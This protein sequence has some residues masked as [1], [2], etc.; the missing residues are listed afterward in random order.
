MGRSPTQISFRVDMGNCCEKQLSKR[1]KDSLSKLNGSDK[2]SSSERFKSTAKG[3][4]SNLKSKQSAENGSSL[5]QEGYDG[6]K[7]ASNSQYP[8]NIHDPKQSNIKAEFVEQNIE[9]LFMKYKA[10][11]VDCILA[12]G[13]E[14]LC[15]DLD[16]DPTEFRVLLLAWKFN[17]SQMCRFTRKEF[18]EGCK[19]LRVDS[20]ASLKS[21]L[22][23][24]EQ[25][26]EDKDIFRDLYRFTYGFGLDVEDGQRTLP[27]P[28]A[29]DLWK[30]VFTKNKPIFLDGWF[31][32]LNENQ[33]KGISRDTWNMFL[34][35]SETIKPDFSNYDESEAWPSLFDEFVAKKLG[36]EGDC[37]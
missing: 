6:A 24:I 18:V 34:H 2:N 33:V 23:F 16:L 5:P 32:F 35:F 31:S 36:D 10:K 17:V 29:M 27:T 15:N 19:G 20:I 30:L 4:S 9:N 7:V 12:H 25:E 28:E 37:H 11:N 22:A 13:T 21:R 8:F 14:K 3:A 1:P 26:T